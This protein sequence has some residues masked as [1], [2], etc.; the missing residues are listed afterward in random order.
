M[1]CCLILTG[2]ILF[3]CKLGLGATATLPTAG[4]SSY[5]HTVGGTSV[6]AGATGAN[7]GGFWNRLCIT[8]GGGALILVDPDPGTIIDGQV[9]IAYPKEM[10]SLTS[11]GWFGPFSDNPALPVPPVVT[12]PFWDSAGEIYDV[13]QPPNAALNVSVTDMAGMLKINFNA[14]PNGIASPA[15]HFNLLVVRLRNISGL[16]LE[17]TQAVAPELAGPGDKVGNLYLPSSQQILRGVPFSSVDGQIVSL[18]ANAPV[19]GYQCAICPE[20]SSLILLGV[21]TLGLLGVGFQ[22]KTYL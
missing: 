1:R 13:E 15:E 9:V 7:G 2:L 17:I 6:L 21:G 11:I 14:S 16:P 19:F 5:S 20:P 10:L 18:S 4:L 12:G 3:S 8:V 22:K